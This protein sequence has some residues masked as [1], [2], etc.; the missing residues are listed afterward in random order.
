MVESPALDWIK[1]LGSDSSLLLPR[2]E[3]IPTYVNVTFS[4]SFMSE[5]FPASNFHFGISILYSLATFLLSSALIVYIVVSFFWFA[6]SLACFDGYDY[7]LVV[8]A[9]ISLEKRYVDDTTG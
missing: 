8:A 1:P 2:G 3:K 5:H 4:S 7:G 9:F 6:F